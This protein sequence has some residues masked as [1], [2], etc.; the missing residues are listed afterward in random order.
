MLSSL[1]RSW[2]RSKAQSASTLTLP[3]S[4]TTRNRTFPDGRPALL[5]TSNTRDALANESAGP[6]GR[7][8][9]SLTI[10]L[11]SQL[12]RAEPVLVGSKGAIEPLVQ[13]DE[14]ALDHEEDPRGFR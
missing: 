14:A 1:Y 3:S 10:V 13:I 11:S 4:P 12:K 6:T 7:H 9:A 8:Q 5:M 2:P